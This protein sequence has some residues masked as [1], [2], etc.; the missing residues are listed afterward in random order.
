MVI[1]FR[2]PCPKSNIDKVS[3]TILC[4]MPRPF[5]DA[6]VKKVLPVLFQEAQHAMSTTRSQSP[7]AS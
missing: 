3:Q 7:Q 5:L 1:T 6:G 2:N 4:L